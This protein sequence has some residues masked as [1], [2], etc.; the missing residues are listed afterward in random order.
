MI[1][2]VIISKGL[3]DLLAHVN[4]NVFLYLRHYTV[5]IAF[6]CVFVMPHISSVCLQNIPATRFCKDV[7]LQ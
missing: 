1:S 5:V 2:I 6:V 7:N 4:V 3:T